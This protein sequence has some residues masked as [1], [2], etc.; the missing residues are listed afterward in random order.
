MR[1]Q[2]Q[3]GVFPE[4]FNCGVR[5]V[6]LL[7]PKIMHFPHVFLGFRIERLRLVRSVV[8]APTENFPFGSLL[9]RESGIQPKR[10]GEPCDSVSASMQRQICFPP[11]CLLVFRASLMWTHSRTSRWGPPEPWTFF[12]GT[13]VARG[14]LSNLADYETE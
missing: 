7:V 2:T 6:G 10:I 11:D 5:S 4:A 8:H 3:D 1:A 12:M 14:V 9:D 13:S